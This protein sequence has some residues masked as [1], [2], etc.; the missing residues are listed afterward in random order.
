MVL[1][2]PVGLDGR[3]NSLSNMRSS[4]RSFR[5]WGARRFACCSATT[6]S[7]RGG[8]KIW[9]VPEL[10]E[11]YIAKMEDVLDLYEHPYNANEPVVCVDERPMQ[12]RGDKRE[13][14]PARP[15][16]PARYDYG[17][18]RLGAANIFCAVEPFAGKHMA[19]VAATRNGAEFAKMLMNIALRYTNADT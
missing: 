8:K 7:S 4:G 3:S 9:C 13:G 19:R 6:S 17:Y 11:E 1:R 5:A 16:K 15:G 14:R 2:R 12:L 18:V 10:D